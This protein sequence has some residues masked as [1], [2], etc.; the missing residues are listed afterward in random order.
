M[1]PQMNANYF[2]NEIELLCL[3]TDDA[4]ECDGPI[5]KKDIQLSLQN[6]ENNKSPGN[7]GL[8][9]EFYVTFLD[10]ISD[11][12]INCYNAC[13]EEEDLT[14]SLWGC[15]FFTLVV[16][17]RQAIITLIKKPG[18]DNSMIKSWRPISLLNVDLK[19]LSKILSRRIQILL[20]KLIGPEQN[21]FVE[22]RNISDTLR[23]ISDILMGN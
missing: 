4:A 9:I 20:P 23:L 22:N 12:L 3:T 10:F 19:I 15:M 16:S 11:D 5:T 1:L 18:K 17:Q 7:D 21:A 14:V 8:P 2:L 13:L 6:M